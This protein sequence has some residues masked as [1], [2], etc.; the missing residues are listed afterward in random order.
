MEI[1]LKEKM[2]QY[3]YAGFPVIYMDTF[4]ED[5]VDALIEAISGTLGREVYEWN[6][7]YGYIDFETKAPMIEDCALETM[8]EQLKEK[9][10]LENKIIVL[11]DI[12]SYLEDMG[13][14]SKLKGIAK[15]ISQGTE[16]TIIIVSDILVIP[17]ELERYI[18]IV[19]I[20]YLNHA[21]IKKIIQNFVSE[22]GLP[23]LEAA[24]LDEFAT[25]FKGLTEFEILN[26]L[27]L[28]YAKDGGL[29]KADLSL[30]F[31]Q[32]QQMIKKAGILEMI[33]LKESMRDIGGL[34]NLKDW[35]KRKAKVY[36]NMAKAK[37]YGVDMPKG[38][39]IAGVP[40]CGKSLNAKAAANLFEVP[41]L[42][43]DLGRLMGKYVGESESNMRNAIALAEAISPCVL[44]IDELEKAFA[45]IGGDGG[46]AEVTTRLFGNFLTWMQEK[47]SPAFVVATANDITKLPPELMRKGRFDEIFYV[48]LPNDKE[49]EK[50]FQIHIGKRR[51]QDLPSIGIPELVAK[52]RGFSGADIEGVIKDAIESAF[53]DGKDKLETKDILTA[54]SN[55]NSLMEIMKDSLETMT[56]FY[57]KSKFKS[58]S[59]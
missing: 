14:V 8:L 33:P 13:V 40:G 20:D 18:T 32:K 35:L 45:G 17:R 47:E 7:T 34:E 49:R 9:E 22:N 50:I 46:G 19:E 27:A 31:D 59:R 29:G 38:V 28:S 12:H 44:W 55:T 26:L 10:L 6:G 58:A 54:I 41:L 36:K 15:L 42:R 37:E 25:A 5:K 1:N 30:I 57:E 24:L 2:I 52:T 16:A 56:K 48:G 53:S 51:P 23:E 21:D 3:I 43:L 39:L 11:K 4:E